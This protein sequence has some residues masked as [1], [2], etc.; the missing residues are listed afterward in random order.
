[1]NNLFARMT[2]EQDLKG[3][4]AIFLAFITVFIVLAILGCFSEVKK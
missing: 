2:A 1:M 4:F 3:C